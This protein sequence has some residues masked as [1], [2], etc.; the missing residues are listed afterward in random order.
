MFP[1]SVV[2]AVNPYRGERPR[3]TLSWNVNENAIEG[4]PF[5]P[6]IEPRET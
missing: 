2:H 5:P 1:G 3:I 6:G 4:S